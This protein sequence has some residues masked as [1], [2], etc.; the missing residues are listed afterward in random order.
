VKVRRPDSPRT[1]ARPRS[2]VRGDVDTRLAALAA[3]AAALL[4]VAVLV[5]TLFT[6]PV[7]VAAAVAALVVAGGCAWIALSHSGPARMLA[8]AAVAV[9]V[10]AAIAALYLGGAGWGIVAFV[11]ALGLFTVASR[12]CGAEPASRVARRDQRRHRAGR[13]V[14]PLPCSS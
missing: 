13:G 10:M 11:V 7:G 1:P 4:A 12:A 6:S 2:G 5:A 14:P 9:A 8:L 3:L